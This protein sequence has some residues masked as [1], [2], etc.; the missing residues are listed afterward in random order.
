[1]SLCSHTINRA[2]IP[3][4]L[5]R[6]GMIPAKAGL[7]INKSKTKGKINTR[8]VDKL[9]LDG[10]EIDEVEDFANPGSNISKD[11]GSFIILSP[12]RKSK[13]MSRKTKLR[14]FNT[15]VKSVLLYGSEAW[16][17]TKATSKKL[18]S[19]VSKCLHTIM[20]MHWPQVIRNKDL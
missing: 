11:G 9:E 2:C 10:E 7:R 14:I 6:K 5:N 18:Q 3:S 15:N 12:V 1:M 20:G 16:R 19:F 13:S 4:R 17:E 8:N